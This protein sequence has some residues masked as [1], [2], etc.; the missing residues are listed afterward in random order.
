V[1][2][3]SRKLDGLQNYLDEA[4]ASAT[5]FDN[6][7]QSAGTRARKS[8]MNIRKLADEIRKEIQ[9]RKNG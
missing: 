8:L 3:I 1:A 9:T 5:K 4:Q 2:S 7:N 6:G